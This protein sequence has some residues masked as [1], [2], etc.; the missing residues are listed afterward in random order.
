MRFLESTKF[1]SFQKNWSDNIGYRFIH[2]QIHLMT[3]ESL[4]DH[5]V[6][7]IDLWPF[8]E[9][10]WEF[11]ACFFSPLSDR[12]VLA[13]FFLDTSDFITVVIFAL[14]TMFWRS[15]FWVGA[16]MRFT[17]FSQC[18]TPYDHQKPSCIGSALIKRMEKGNEIWKC[19]GLLNPRLTLRLRSYR[20]KVYVMKFKKY[21]LFQFL[22]KHFRIN[23]NSEDTRKTII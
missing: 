7:G 9:S 22:V 13:C 2:F 17:Y 1:L 8:L 16:V 14:G 19:L 18:G 4:L 3:L 10:K 21:E 5:T 12:V 11:G 20:P 23:I 15:I 6:W